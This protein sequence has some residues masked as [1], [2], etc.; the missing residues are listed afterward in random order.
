AKIGEFELSLEYNKKSLAIFKELNNNGY[1]A[2]MLNNLGA[3]Y[4][5]IGNYDLALKYY[6][7]S[8]VV[9]EQDPIQ[10][11]API[12]GLIAVALE[13][14]DT[15]RAQKYFKRLE[16]LYNKKK[17]SNIEIIY[18]YIKAMTLKRSSRIRDKA[19]A[20]E[21]LKQVIETKSLFFDLIIDA[22]INL[23]DLLLSEFRISK[24]SEALDELNYYIT[25]LL[26][27]AETSHSY[28]VFCEVFIL[29][30]KLALIN[31]N[32]KIAR[33]FLTQAQRIAESYGIKRLA[34]KISYEHDQLIKQL[35]VWEKLKESEAPL[36]ERW[37]L[38]GLNEQIENM[39]RKRMT[40]A[41]K[42]SE[43]DP[44]S[45]FII[46]EGGTPLFSHSF[47]DQ[48]SFESYLFSGFLTT[49]DYFIREMFSEGL[50][51]AIFG[52]HTLLLKSIPPFYISYIF[53]GDSYHA[54]QKLNYF[55]DHIQMEDIW[56]SLLKSFKINQ[57]IH[58]KDLPLLN[59]L[60]TDTF[61]N[62]SIPSKQG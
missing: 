20:E 50:D 10:I 23:C 51:R 28:L 39:V 18:Q 8:L 35:N 31:F 19:K 24:N 55:T 16:N 45:I 52:E 62:K 34:M 1:I 48:K 17:N 32:L 36:S 27:I 46:T 21:L 29:Q 12:S 2:L 14:G 43:E 56:Q 9:W 40:E 26:T 3:T 57:S 41:P 37:K 11:E 47:I 42:I 30:A 4:Q 15:E 54:L 22:Y 6:E 61:I 5:D 25:K 38:A 59:S 44:V 33:R 60:I 7:E 58:L 49:I 53:K 13:K